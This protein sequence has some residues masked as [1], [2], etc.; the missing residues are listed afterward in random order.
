MQ[1]VFKMHPK[2]VRSLIYL[3]ISLVLYWTG[4]TK[5]K[6]KIHVETQN[7]IPQEGIMDAILL[8]VILLGVEDIISFQLIEESSAESA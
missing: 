7:W 1:Y 3:I 6:K 4:H 2:S 8:R 5:A